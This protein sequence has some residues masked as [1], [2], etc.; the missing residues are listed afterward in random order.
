[1]RLGWIVASLRRRAV[2]CSKVNLVAESLTV[3]TLER[4]SARGKAGTVDRFEDERSI[5]ERFVLES[6]Y[7]SNLTA[8]EW[9]RSSLRSWRCRLRRS[10]NRGM[11][12][13]SI[14]PWDGNGL[15]KA[16][17]CQRRGSA[18]ALARCRQ[19]SRA[20]HLEGRSRKLRTCASKLGGRLVSRAIAA[21]LLLVANNIR[22]VVLS[23]HSGL[24][25]LRCRV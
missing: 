13:S 22:P 15:G 10:E 2:A 18:P 11:S 16:T 5:E 14:R 19:A 17:S 8:S 23:R 12:R 25:S 24:F 21:V 6:I 1:M 4:L 9:C 20:L 3:P 7:R